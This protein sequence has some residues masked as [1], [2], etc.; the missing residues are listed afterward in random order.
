MELRRWWML[1]GQ[2][3]KSYQ[4]NIFHL[5]GTLE[6]RKKPKQPPKSK[7]FARSFAKVSL[8]QVV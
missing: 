2:I 4:P 6:N 3:G 7:E 1:P 5:V 8:E